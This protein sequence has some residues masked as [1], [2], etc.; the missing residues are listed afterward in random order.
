MLQNYRIREYNNDDSEDVLHFISDMIV[1]EF[2]I[3]LDFD[4]LDS[5]LLQINQHYKDNG[6]CFWIVERI[7]NYQIIGTVAIRK[8]EQLVSTTANTID[9][10]DDV[11]NTAAAELKRMF[12]LKPYRGLGIGQQMLDTA[13]NFAKKSGYSKILLYS[14]KTLTVSRS[15]YLKNGFV[16]IPRYND[17]HRADIF[18][19]KKL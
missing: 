11:A 16:D 15:L 12:L 2:D 19:G 6:G 8:L 18:M 1:N 9:G 10:D 5:D 7:D 14:S 3:T 4:N 13:L 17:D